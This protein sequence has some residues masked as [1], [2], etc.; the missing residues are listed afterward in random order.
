MYEKPDPKPSFN[1]PSIWQALC[2]QPPERLNVFMTKIW[3]GLRILWQHKPHGEFTITELL[4]QTIIPALVRTASPDGPRQ[5]RDNDPF[6]DSYNLIAA[7]WDSLGRPDTANGL[8]IPLVRLARL[9]SSASSTLPKWLTTVPRTNRLFWKANA[10]LSITE[11]GIPWHIIIA[12]SQDVLKADYFPLLH[13]YTVLVSQS[14]IH[15]S[16]PSQWPMRRHEVMNFVVE[17]CCKKIGGDI[18][19]GKPT[20]E[21]KDVL[22]MVYEELRKYQLDKNKA[23]LRGHDGEESVVKGVWAL[24]A[25]SARNS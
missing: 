14:I 17:R 19:S 23:S 9:M 12:A 11:H 16:Q 21:F 8:A 22:V 13:L 25:W 7:S 24:A 2:E 15:A 18:W 5:I 10:C 4:N 1:V 3:Y 6:L 20:N